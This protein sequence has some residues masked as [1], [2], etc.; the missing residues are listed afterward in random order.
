[1]LS[2]ADSSESR[3]IISLNQPIEQA[4]LNLNDIVNNKKEEIN[5]IVDSLAIISSTA[6]PK[7]K[8]LMDFNEAQAQSNQVSTANA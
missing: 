5:I 4:R 1:L 8:M 7:E 3:K 6:L 2:I